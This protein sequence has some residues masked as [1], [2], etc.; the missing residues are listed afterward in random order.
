MDQNLKFKSN[1]K[2]RIAII[3]GS[4]DSTISKSHLRSILAS[5]KFRIACGCFSRNKNNNGKNSENYSIPKEKIYNDYQKLINL[6]HKN[7]DIALILTPPHNKYNI[8]Y[9]LAKKN[10]G[11]ISE[12]PFEGNLKK[13]NKI[14]KFL[15]KKKNI[16]F[17]HL[18]LPR[19]S[20]YF[21]N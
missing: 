11:I 17:N 4:Y 5:N 20:C 16:L 8:Y 3:G 18:Q 19:L 14:Y 12:K 2:I 21:R 6:E 10:I 9:E 15:K 1:K 13:A 7:I